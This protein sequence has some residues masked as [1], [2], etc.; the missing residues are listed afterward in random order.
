MKIIDSIRAPF[1]PLNPP[2]SQPIMEFTKRDDWL[3]LLHLFFLFHSKLIMEGT[4][5]DDQL[6]VMI[7]TCLLQLVLVPTLDQ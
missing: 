4:K 3:N 5:R 7:F 2:F 6:F 1:P